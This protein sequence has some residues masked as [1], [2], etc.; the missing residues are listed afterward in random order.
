MA[1]RLPYATKADLYS[2]GATLFACVERVPPY[3]HLAQEQAMKEVVF[4][5]FPAFSNPDSMSNGLKDFIKRCTE[6]IPSMRATA[7]EMLSVL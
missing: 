4:F 7:K 5:G 1:A 2:A 3:G 6:K